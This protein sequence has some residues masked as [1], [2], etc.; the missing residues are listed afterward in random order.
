MTESTRSNNKERREGVLICHEDYDLIFPVLRV[1][2]NWLCYL[3][4]LIIMMVDLSS[5]I[6]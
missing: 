3:R 1:V 6:V 5:D 2:D 4:C